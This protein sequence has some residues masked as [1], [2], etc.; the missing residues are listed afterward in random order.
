MAKSGTLSK[1]MWQFLFNPSEL[2]IEAGPEFKVAETWG[3]SDK[4]NSGQPLNWSHNKNT[5]LKFNSVLLNGFVF[6]RKV[7]ELE[8]GIFELF[9]ARDGDGQAGPPILEFVWGKRVFG[10]CV[11]KEI[12]IKEKMWD[13]GMVVNAELSFTLEQIPE[14][15]IN[16]GYVDV[17]R[18][19]KI[20]MV[21]DS[22]EPSGNVGAGTTTTPFNTPPGGGTGSPDQKKQTPVQ[23]ADFVA[24]K[25][26]RELQL[27]A[28]AFNPSPG[29]YYSIPS[30]IP[31]GGG[32]NTAN[33]VYQS[34]FTKN[35]TTYKTFLD[36][37]NSIGVS[38]STK[39]TAAT[40]MT[41]H[42]R[43]IKNANDSLKEMADKQM[44]SIMNGC[45]AE[46]G[47]KASGFYVQ[48]GCRRFQ[49]NVNSNT[50][51]L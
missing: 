39:C 14:W 26:L 49:T 15:T 5:Q 18:P 41:E 42:S 44:A 37:G 11:I 43:L 4:A 30:L 45:A 27:N 8:Q 48:K 3:V 35:Y 13:E 24:C 28:I 22:T 34:N 25:N 29:S 17:A 50:E 47:N 51:R 46:L 23:S 32:V 20:P 10:P 7:E 2:E 36:K 40:I 19:G 38:T 31:F 33:K 6:G 12:S 16:D 1:G 9:L 21:Y